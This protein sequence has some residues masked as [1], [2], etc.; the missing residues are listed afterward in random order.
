M[1]IVAN[2]ADCTRVAIL[3]STGANRLVLLA[4]DPAED[5]TRYGDPYTYIK[6]DS[7]RY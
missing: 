2:A 7:N 3:D 1:T 4:A 5:V 6:P